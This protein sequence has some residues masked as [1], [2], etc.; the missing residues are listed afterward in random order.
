LKWLNQA[1]GLGPQNLRPKNNFNK[2]HKKKPNKAPKNFNIEKQIC[3]RNMKKTK[4]KT[5]NK[6][7]DKPSPFVEIAKTT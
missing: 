4:T 6:K 5:K 7:F 2:A 1:R 3:Y